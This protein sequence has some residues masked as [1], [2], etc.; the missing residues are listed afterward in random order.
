[1]KSLEKFNCFEEKLRITIKTARK[2][3][4]I[5][6]MYLI[7]SFLLIFSSICIF[8]IYNL[9]FHSDSAASNIFAREQFVQRSFFPSTWKNSTGIFIFYVNVF[10]TPLFGLIKDQMLLR[11][12]GIL[13]MA[14]VMYGC[15]FYMSKHTLNSNCFLLIF[16][17]LNTNICGVFVHC[18]FQQ[19]CYTPT[20][21]HNIIYIFFLANV[22]DENFQIRN[23]I[24]FGLWVIFT[25]Y[26]ASYGTL[27]LVYTIFPG[28]L[29]LIFPLLLND[30]NKSFN[31]CKVKIYAILKV[32][33]VLFLSC[34]VGIFAYRQLAN[35]YDFKSQVN[36]Q[37]PEITQLANAF[38]SFML[39]SIGY[40]TG[41][42]LFSVS[43]LMN[44]ITVCFHVFLIICIFKFYHNLNKYSISVQKLGG[45]AF[46]IFGI[47]MFFDFFVYC[48]GDANHRYTVLPLVFLYI[49]SAYYIW[50]EI[51]NK[52]F[53]T[54]C[55]V[56][57]SVCLICL[58]NNLVV[59]PTIMDYPV[60]IEQKKGL[61]NF[62]K[63]NNLERGYATFWNAGNNM[64]LSDFDVEIAPIILDSEQLFRYEWL[65]STR[66]Y[67]DKND[68]NKSFLLLTSEEYNEVSESNSLSRLG[69][70]D[71]VLQFGEYFILDYSY[72]IAQNN[73]SGT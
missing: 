60:L 32:L 56:I 52:G 6:I 17:F 64:V 19:A 58:P 20:V 31:E 54:K 12:I 1:M 68:M 45:F 30:Y 10:M 4:G 62:L 65:T 14:L 42:N 70:P 33:W 47:Y 18:L 50:E 41:I 37:F 49:V 51:F 71:Q 43:G 35:Y 57:I 48:L 3:P 67:E 55:I 73:F 34:C 25:I 21:I 36:I 63:T 23:K 15:I 27:G 24:C 2:N 29:G 61:A 66:Y 28:I 69:T 39:Y 38:I 44:I 26:L 40:T 22:F 59:I 11:D 7:C 53:L 5:F 16:C 13:I 8:T 72:N 46:G 9:A